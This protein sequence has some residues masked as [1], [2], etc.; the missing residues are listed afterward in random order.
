MIVS[1]G[2]FAVVAFSA[3]PKSVVT[4][5]LLLASLIRQPKLEALFLIN[6]SR[7]A[8][9]VTVFVT[10]LVV[11]VANDAIAAPYESAWAPFHV[12]RAAHGERTGVTSSV[13]LEP[14]PR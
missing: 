10:P 8:V 13:W 3:A 4:L 12:E 14:G 11:P 9:T 1:W 2:W 5:E 6:A 7:S